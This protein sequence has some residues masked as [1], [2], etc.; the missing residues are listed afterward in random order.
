MRNRLDRS[1]FDRDFD[2]LGKGLGVLWVAAALIWVASTVALIW[3]LVLL[4]QWVIS[5]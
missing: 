5:K 3:A 1:D 2:R 4:V